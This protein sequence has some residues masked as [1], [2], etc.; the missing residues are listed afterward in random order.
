MPPSLH[1]TLL[2]DFS[3]VD[4]GTPIT[5]VDTP[6]LQSL[7]AYLLLHR[8]APQARQQL[9]YLFWPDSTEKQARTNLRR[10]LHNLRHA[11]PEPDRY[12]AI[13]TS[14][15]QW[16]P[17]APYTLDVD[18]FEA[19][20]A[21]GRRAEKSTDGSSF[22]S[23]LAQAAAT[24]RGDLLPGCYD[25]W[26]TGERERLRGLSIWALGQ[27]VIA[28]EEAHDYAAATRYAERV[29]T[30]DP[31]HDTAC[32]A[33]MRLHAL[34]GQRA[35]ALRAYRA[36]AARLEEE[37]GV[38]PDPDTR[39]LYQQ[40]LTADTAVTPPVV[41][42]GITPLVGRVAEWG[43]LLRAWRVSV[44]GHGQLALIEGEAGIGKSRL[45]EELRTWASRQGIATAA[46]RSY[47]AE[48]EHVY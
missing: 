35:S 8:D 18:E 19:A 15:L 5:G 4:G 11:L 44:Q 17:N 43:Q 29:L 23:S 9:A 38:E 33:L 28:L 40:L 46:A 27:L 47:A 12:L 3:L 14:T 10:E 20:I 7:L 24:Y 6:R 21:A 42:P 37:F 45:A 30:I 22:R 39:A 36:Y 32:R 31:L 34:N 26:I 2:G 13:G 1:I 25:D 41:L 16:R 48:G